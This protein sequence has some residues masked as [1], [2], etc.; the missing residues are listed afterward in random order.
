MI[1]LICDSATDTPKEILEKDFVEMVP[2]KVIINGKEYKDG[3]GI[4]Q[5]EVLEAM[6]YTVPKTSLPSHEDIVNAYKTLIDKGYNEIFV[7]TVPEKLSGT[8]G[9][10]NAIA[11]EIKEMYSDVSIEVVD[12]KSGSLG[13]AMIISK[14]AEYIEEGKSFEYI[15][16]QLDILINGKSKVFFVVPTLKYLKAG[17]RI[18]KVSGTLG[19]VLNVK[20]IIS[21][22]DEGEFHEVGRARGMNKAI[23]KLVSSFLQWVGERKLEFLA[24]AKSGEKEETVNYF[25]YVKSKL[26]HLNPKKIFTGEISS[27]ALVHLGE[28]L[29]GVGGLL[30]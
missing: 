7:I 25:N 12:S 23:D 20:P 30:E 24:I 8:F 6:K 9:L 10:F 5:Q 17:G 2:L 27:V 26:K 28:G 13:A 4:T 16:G 14:V 15:R 18:G 19:E 21:I 1:G 3:I 22:N 29:V 11:E